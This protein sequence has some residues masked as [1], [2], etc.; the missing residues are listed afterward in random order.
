M[1]HLPELL[2]AWL[3]GEGERQRRRTP[4]PARVGD[5]AVRGRVQAG[6]CVLAGTLAAGLFV[7]WLNTAWGLAGRQG[8]RPT[9]LEESGR[10]LIAD[11]IVAGARV[12]RITPE[13]GAGGGA[14]PL[15]L[16]VSHGG[17]WISCAFRREKAPRGVRVGDTVSIR[18]A[19]G[20]VEVGTGTGFV[21]LNDC[22]VI[23]G[24]HRPGG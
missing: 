4:L 11:V 19:V 9:W 21:L 13:V 6:V 5:P 10:E 17:R 24:L 1:D 23:E 7:C 16:D 3:E 8:P 14:G 18:S 12:E 2:V 15:T 20:W 22:E